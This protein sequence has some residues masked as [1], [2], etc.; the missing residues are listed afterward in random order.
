[1]VFNIFYRRSGKDSGKNSGKFIKV[2]SLDITETSNIG[3]FYLL[4]IKL[5]PAAGIET[6]NY[7]NPI[8]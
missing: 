6:I 7:N 4:D 1:M 8:M 3:A 5:V 2:K